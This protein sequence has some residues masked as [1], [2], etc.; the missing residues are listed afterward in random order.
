MSNLDPEM[1]RMARKDI[2]RGE[3][4][5]QHMI[6]ATVLTIRENPGEPRERIIATLINR[7]EVVSADDL[8]LMWAAA[9]MK[10]AESEALGGGPPQ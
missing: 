1:L 5:N 4:A 7:M 10:V 9:V 2:K 8:L 3:I 6:E